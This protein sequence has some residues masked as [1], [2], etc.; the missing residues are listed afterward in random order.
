MKFIVEFFEKKKREIRKARKLLNVVFLATEMSPIHNG[1]T[2]T[3]T[4]PK[5]NGRRGGMEPN[6]GPPPEQLRAPDAASEGHDRTHM[7]WSDPEDAEDGGGWANNE[8]HV[9]GG[10]SVSTQL[11]E[12]MSM[13]RMQQE[14][15]RPR[16]PPEQDV[17]GRADALSGKL[18]QLQEKLGL[19]RNHQ[20]P[21]NLTAESSKML[22]NSERPK[23]NFDHYMRQ[24]SNSPSGFSS[25]SSNNAAPPP[26]PPPPLSFGEAFYEVEERQRALKR[27]QEQLDFQKELEAKRKELEE[28]LRSKESFFESRKVPKRIPV[29]TPTSEGV[30]IQRQLLQMQQEIES[31]RRGPSQQGF[32]G[33][34]VMMIIQQQQWQIQ[35]LSQ[36]VTQCYNALLSL[37][38]DL[39]HFIMTA[40]PQRPEH[41]ERSYSSDHNS[42]VV[43]PSIRNQSNEEQRQSSDHDTARIHPYESASAANPSGWQNFD[44]LDMVGAAAGPSSN[45]D[46]R[47][48]SLTSGSFNNGDAWDF[49]DHHITSPNVIRPT[50]SSA[51]VA[52]PSNNSESALNNQVPPGMRANNYWDNF[53]SFSRQNRFSS[54]VSSVAPTPPVA[55]A[56]TPMIA[57]VT[58]RQ[59]QSDRS[60]RPAAVAVGGI[61]RSGRHSATVEPYFS[62][63]N[64][65]SRPK[66]KQKINREQNREIGPMLGP[67]RNIAAAAAVNDFQ[68][69]Q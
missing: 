22:R 34:E 66:R 7:R 14:W 49:F 59:L 50:V 58:P 65:P 45:G 42:A 2:S 54:V 18:L 46:H 57:Q 53:R 12:L 63:I 17:M 11:Q 1:L 40:D 41:R 69:V 55:S 39:G 28:L 24:N 36:S 8:I 33:P 5:S 61:A 48:L 62:N 21:Q 6:S 3:G 29:P 60:G 68:S 20:H 44:T 30:S 10:D 15:F 19:M 27:M 4:I 23:L 31:L 52:Q 16:P 9:N 64:S 56:A 35:Q 26:P 51:T 37:Q 38:R 43:A 47:R 25:S 13:L 32:G 67:N